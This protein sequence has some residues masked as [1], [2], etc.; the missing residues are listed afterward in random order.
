MRPL[1]ALKIVILL[2]ARHVDNGAG[3]F[4]RDVVNVNIVIYLRGIGAPT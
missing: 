3:S 2:P 1:V 4:Q